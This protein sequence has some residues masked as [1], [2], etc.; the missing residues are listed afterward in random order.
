MGSNAPSVA[1]QTIR[2]PS[3][4]LATYDK[5]PELVAL[6]NK[7]FVT[8]W[9]TIPGIVGPDATRYQSDQQF[10][11]EMG[12]GGVTF[13]AFNDRGEMVATAGYKPWITAWKIAERMKAWKGSG[14]GVEKE[15]VSRLSSLVCL[16]GD[17]L[18]LRWIG[19]RL[20]RCGDLA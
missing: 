9:A 1:V 13:V 10:V 16:I 19:F 8:S 12:V 4:S 20:L 5:L 17:L 14:E 3:T 18:Q 15:A 11:D 6:I 2:L 7:A